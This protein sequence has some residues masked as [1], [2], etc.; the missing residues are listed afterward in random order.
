MTKST[1]LA[2]LGGGFLLSSGATQRPVR[3]KLGERVSVLDFGAVSGQDS[4][5]AIIDAISYV[6]SL[7]GGTIFFPS[8]T[9]HVSSQIG[10]RSNLALE[11]EP[12]SKIFFETTADPYGLRCQN[13]SRIRLKGISFEGPGE[14]GVVQSLLY[15][16][17][18]SDL[19]IEDCEFIKAGNIAVYC[20]GSQRIKVYDSYF[21]NSG[22]YGSECKSCEDVLYVG[23]RFYKNGDTGTE[24]TAG[25]RGLVLWMTSNSYVAGNSFIENT[26]YGFRFYSQASDGLSQVT[27]GRIIGNYFFNNTRCDVV[28]YNETTNPQV[29]RN[30][31]AD[32]IIERTA[33]PTL[34][35]FF[36]VQ[37]HNNTVVNCHCFNLGDFSTAVAFN[38]SGALNTQYS[39]LIGC[40]A[41]NMRSGFTF[42]ESTN[43][44]VEGFDGV[45]IGR[46]GFPYGSG[47][48]VRGCRLVHGGPG[49]TDICF[50]N[51]NPNGSI[52][53][54][55]YYYDNILD[56]FH[57]GFYIANG[58]DVS[59]FNNKTV[60]STG[61]GLIVIG[62]D[63]GVELVGNSFDSA[64]PSELSS[65]T[66]SFGSGERA[67]VYNTAPPTNLTWQVG[68]RCY[69]SSP[70]IGQPK[71]WVC[72]VAGSPGTWT[73]EGD[74]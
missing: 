13:R 47:N 33:E 21:A 26:E 40:S 72:T 8:G 37:G 61:A 50:R 58:R 66:R 68:D 34:G 70:A 27:G 39:K 41:T 19:L 59:L 53:G 67:R 60:N 36:T 64:S 23:N 52:L 11:G 10:L 63:T 14:V 31:L 28:L 22:F 49:T 17:S 46:C 30:I 3:E 45:G 24:T 2:N 65:L 73:S 35:A 71:S 7:G 57:Y 18:S 44:T 54:R 62:D 1:D 56:G 16:Q 29:A 48:V 55:N 5:Q 4:T 25:G 6:D 43:T 12:G 9:Y 20:L 69:N 15:F 38:F 51:D 74:L 42:G 32:N